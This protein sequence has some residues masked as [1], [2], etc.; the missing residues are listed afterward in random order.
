VDVVVAAGDR[1]RRSALIVHRRD[2]AATYAVDE[3]TGGQTGYRTLLKIDRGTEGRVA[4]ARFDGR[5]GFD[6][7]GVAVVTTESAVAKGKS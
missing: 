6:G 7:Y 3:L 1:G 4:T 5:V 2:E